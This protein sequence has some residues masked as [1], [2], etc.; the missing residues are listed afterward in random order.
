MDRYQWRD[1]YAMVDGQ[2]AWWRLE[3]RVRP[4]TALNRLVHWQATFVRRSM[5]AVGR[6][7]PVCDTNAW[8]CRGRI[9][10][11]LARLGSGSERTNDLSVWL[12]GVG[13]HVDLV[14]NLWTAFA[15]VHRGFVPRG[16]RQTLNRVQ[17]PP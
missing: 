14:P 6:S 7:L 1:R 11:G 12:P 5:W 8:R 17:Q 9:W 16:L 3:I 15:G 4:A 13:A 2:M 10:R